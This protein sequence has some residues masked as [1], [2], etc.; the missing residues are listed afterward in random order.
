MRVLDSTIRA[1]TAGS[2]SDE[3]WPST[4]AAAAQARLST[5]QKLPAIPRASPGEAGSDRSHVA[6]V[7]F[8]LRSRFTTAAFAAAGE[9]RFVSLLDGEPEASS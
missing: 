8:R 7:C 6:V 4:G 3:A 1:S 9:V 5:Q 2:T